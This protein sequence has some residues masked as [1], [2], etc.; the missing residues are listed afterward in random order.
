MTDSNDDTEKA[1]E[2]KAKLEAAKRMREDS[3][4]LDPSG[5]PARV[6]KQHEENALKDIAEGN[7]WM[8][9]QT[10]DEAWEA[11]ERKH[12]ERFA[13]KEKPKRARPANLDQYTAS[14]K[15]AWSNLDDR[16]PARF[17][18]TNPS[19]EQKAVAA[20]EPKEKLAYANR[21]RD[22]AARK[23]EADKRAKKP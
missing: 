7:P 1:A 9:S 23:A 2:N 17:I 16:V 18:R 10:S 20:L 3:A 11:Y 5:A 22:E 8:L 13:P 14:E 6:L 4:N 15:L 21:K 12:P 19:D